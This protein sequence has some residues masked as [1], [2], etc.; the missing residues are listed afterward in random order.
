MSSPVT[1][2]DLRFSDENAVATGWDETLH[3][4][5]AAEM[6]WV[7]TVRGDG[8]PHTTPLV[9]VWVG[10]ALYFCTGDAEQKAVNLRSNAHVTLTT[11]C[12]NWDSGLDVVVEGNAVPVTDNDLLQDLAHAWTRRW[13]G[14]WQFQVGDGGFRHQD[15]ASRVLVFEVKPDRVLAFAKGNPFSYTRHRF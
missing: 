4:L 11:G 13:D 5:E 1:T 3:A 8:R 10:E 7:T 6:W 14:R 2:L 12:N 15:A 9:A